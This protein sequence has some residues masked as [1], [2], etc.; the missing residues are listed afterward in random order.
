MK[1]AEL[2]HADLTAV[3]QQLATAQA[4]YFAT[5]EAIRTGKEKNHAQLRQ[6][7]RQIARVRTILKEQQSKN[8]HSPA[9]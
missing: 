9:N 2:R 5:Q 3:T 8:L 7:R 6:L 4:E 1:S